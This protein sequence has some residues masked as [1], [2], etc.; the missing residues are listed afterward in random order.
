MCHHVLVYEEVC[1]V[2]VREEYI[3]EEY[4]RE[5]YIREGASGGYIYT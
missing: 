4:I 5:E 3:R 2:L 1:L